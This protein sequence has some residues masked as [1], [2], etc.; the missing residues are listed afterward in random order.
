[1]LVALGRVPTIAN[2]ERTINRAV[3]YLRIDPLQFSRITPQAIRTIRLER[4]CRDLLRTRI[5]LQTRH[6]S[7]YRYN[8]KVER[9]ISGI[10]TVEYVVDS[11]LW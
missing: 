1:M 8:S 3:H 7:M 10:P 5:S 9:P 6:L 11:G 2:A 4:Y